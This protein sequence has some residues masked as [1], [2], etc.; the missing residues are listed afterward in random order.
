MT[1][2]N[3]NASWDISIWGKLGLILV[4][5]LGTYLFLSAD[6]P[7]PKM[8]AEAEEQGYIQTAEKHL[9]YYQNEEA[10]EEYTKAIDI[11]PNNAFSR[12]GR[13]EALCRR[14]K[15]KL[16]LKD[17]TAALL[18]D[19]NLIHAYK[20]KGEVLQG[21][22]EYPGSVAA[23]SRY[24]EYEPR[25]VDGYFERAYSYFNGRYTVNRTYNDKAIADFQKALDLNPIGAHPGRGAPARAR[26]QASKKASTYFGLGLAYCHKKDF[27]S[28]LEAFEQSNAF[29]P[30]NKSTL[31]YIERVTEKLQQA[32]S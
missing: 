19:S 17:I 16:A 3:K 25:D 18:L 8:L 14:G 23:L 24:L 6:R 29:R 5:A 30:G 20:V 15:Y 10:T 27:E 31:R 21:L 1:P 28:A 2:S 4:I 12:C 13:A 26:D 11:N 7:T 22:H 32:E 9:Y